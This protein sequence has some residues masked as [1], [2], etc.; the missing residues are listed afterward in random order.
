MY[1]FT[2]MYHS[3]FCLFLVDTYCSQLLNHC[4]DYNLHILIQG[5][6]THVECQEEFINNR[7]RNLSFTIIDDSKKCN[8]SVIV[9]KPTMI[10][11]TVIISAIVVTCLVI[12]CVAT[13]IFLCC[14][15]LYRKRN[16][17][18]FISKK[19][20]AMYNFYIKLSSLFCIIVIVLSIQI[21]AN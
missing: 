19:S 11:H 20:I 4:S 15:M 3:D 14:M 10:N 7:I 13:S 12:L 8:K 16:R 18:R 21:K 2:C 5:N 9:T 1:K 17:K 6:G